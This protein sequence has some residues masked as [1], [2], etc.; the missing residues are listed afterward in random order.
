MLLT[1]H[2]DAKEWNDSSDT[3][4]KDQ[5]SQDGKRYVPASEALDVTVDIPDLPVVFGAVKIIQ[6]WRTL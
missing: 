5:Y 1:N 3:Q 6:I 2:L 4:N